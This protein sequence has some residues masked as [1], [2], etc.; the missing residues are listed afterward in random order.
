[1]ERRRAAG[2]GMEHPG[3]FRR[4]G[5]FTLAEIAK[6]TG[7]E[8]APGG[9]PAETLLEDVR[10][11]TDAGPRH[12]SFFNN[13]KYADQLKATRAGACL[14]LPAFAARVPDTTGKLV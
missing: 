13:R 6:A 11:L 8:L 9:I 12:L 1:M 5:P 14:V 3:F 7:A 4:A 2:H 10:T